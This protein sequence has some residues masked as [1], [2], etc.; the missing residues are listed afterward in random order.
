MGLSTSWR[1]DDQSPCR[2]SHMRSADDRARF[3][4]IGNIGVRFGKTAASSG[5]LWRPVSLS[6]SRRGFAT[7]KRSREFCSQLNSSLASTAYR[8]CRR[9]PSRL[10]LAG[11]ISL[12]SRVGLHSKLRW[13]T[14]DRLLLEARI[15]DSS[16]VLPDRAQVQWDR[17][18]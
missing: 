10:P 1:K 18:D 7:T 9:L 6:L 15:C 3:A 17:S 5:R 2:W 11:W 8:Q 12:D 14:W 13:K 4:V 16:P